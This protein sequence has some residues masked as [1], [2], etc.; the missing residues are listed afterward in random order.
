MSKLSNNVGESSSP[1]VAYA[2]VRRRQFDPV[3]QET[4]PL[5]VAAVA[6]RIRRSTVLHPVQIAAL[7]GR[8]HTKE[9]GVNGD[10]E[11]STTKSVVVE[12]R[13]MVVVSKITTVFSVT[14]DGVTEGVGEGNGG[15]VGYG[16]DEAA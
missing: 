9:P 6:V 11:E 14:G 8:A 2:V 13:R 15:G 5:V 12:Q 4:P 10:G 16:E 7:F 3:G 1:A